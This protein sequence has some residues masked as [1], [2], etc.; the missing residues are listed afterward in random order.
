MEYG[1]VGHHGGE[2][3]GAPDIAGGAGDYYF[4]GVALGHGHD[5]GDEGEGRVLVTELPAEEE[6]FGG[7]GVGFGEEL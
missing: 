4:M 6:K 7:G 2:K 5:I 1:G 3:L